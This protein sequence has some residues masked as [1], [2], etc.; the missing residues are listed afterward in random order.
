MTRGRIAGALMGAAVLALA[1]NLGH[2]APA[3]AG[4]PAIFERKKAQASAPPA[5]ASPV[6][7][8]SASVAPSIPP[9]EASTGIPSTAPSE[10]PT[11]LATAPSAT[12]EA[13]APAPTST[14]T[15]TPAPTPTPEPSATA[16][17]TA[18]PA[19]SPSASTSAL[20]EIRP[21]VAGHRTIP[22]S[23]NDQ[24]VT[25]MV[26][27]PVDELVLFD[28]LKGT[29]RSHTLAQLPAGG[30]RDLGMNTYVFAPVLK[31]RWIFGAS[32]ASDDEFY[33]SYDV[34]ARRYVA[35]RIQG[36][37]SYGLWVS[38]DGWRGN[39]IVFISNDSTA[40]GR[41]Y[42][43]RMTIEHP[44]ARA[45]DIIDE[46]QRPDGSWSTDDVLEMTKQAS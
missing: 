43:R 44:S 25:K 6:A 18:T 14:Q 30:S 22:E 23:M 29:W 24:R 11:T 34:F 17:P 9:A 16:T 7:I 1:A 38:Y 46:E 40:F 12:T 41:A 28:W 42:V 19:P 13:P 31:G 4:T 45:F 35:L 36:D 26:S 39:R 37:P 2:T 32:G 15:P 33:I 3:G 21:F 20:P 5:S 27:A 8:P 10:A